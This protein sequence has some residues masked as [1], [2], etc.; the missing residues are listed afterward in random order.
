MQLMEDWQ[1][2]RATRANLLVIGTDTSI[3]HAMEA[4]RP[5]LP[6]PVATWR[7]GARLVLPTAQSGTF[8]LEEVGTL[9][10]HEQLRLLGWLDRAFGR[11]QVVSTSRTPLL[12]HIE[13]GTFSETLYYRLNTV[14]V[15]MAA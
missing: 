15:L 7:P 2:A 9:S 10:P 3:R 5:N 13:R 4:L 8:V 12:S 11:T 14:C 1:L 6:E